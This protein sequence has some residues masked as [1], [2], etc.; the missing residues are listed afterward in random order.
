MHDFHW[1]KLT[2]IATNINKS[3]IK[4]PNVHK[5]SKKLIEQHVKAVNKMQKQKYTDYLYICIFRNC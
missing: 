1:L 2:K 4:S 5:C 3:I